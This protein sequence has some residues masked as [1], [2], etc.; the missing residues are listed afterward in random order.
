[1]TAIRIQYKTILDFSN[2]NINKSQVARAIKTVQLC[3]SSKEDEF[4]VYYNDIVVGMYIVRL[5]GAPRS[6]LGTKK[7]ENFGFYI[8]EAGNSDIRAFD[9]WINLRKNP[10]FNQQYWASSEGNISAIKSK[11]IVNIIMHC[12]RLNSLKS[13]L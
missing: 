3:S 10:L 5:F 12:N 4:S 1:M 2:Q 13:F 6:E 11:D 9:K 7:W 8:Y